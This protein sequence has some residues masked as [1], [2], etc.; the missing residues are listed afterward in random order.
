MIVSKPELMALAHLDHQGAALSPPVLNFVFGPGWDPAAIAEIRALAGN[1]A[2]A[3]HAA[4][5]CSTS[6]ATMQRRWRC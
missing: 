6:R 1:T 3:A 4:S 2:S 5:R